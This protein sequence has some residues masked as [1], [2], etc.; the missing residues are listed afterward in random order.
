MDAERDMQ[1]YSHTHMSRGRR[2]V[3]RVFTW[4][5][6]CFIIAIVSLV[7]WRVLLSDRIPPDAKTLL[8]NEATKEAYLAHGDELIVCTQRQEKLTRLETDEGVYGLF[9]VSQSRFLPQAQQIQLLV[10]YNNST[11][12]YIAKD[13][14]LSEVPARDRDVIDVTLRVT[15]DP[16]PSEPKSGDEHTE[17]YHASAA[18]LPFSTAMY[19]YRAL[20]FDGVSIEDAAVQSISVDFYYLDRM[21]Y[22][23]LPYG[24]LCIF[25]AERETEPLELTARDRR[26]L[27][28]YRD[29]E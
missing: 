4:I 1:E 28:S 25:D 7:L 17:R 13:F 22:S 16:T 5:F 20:V 19:N 18:P 6:R 14:K 11:L 21:D 29:K 3:G 26:A 27:E 23:D 15:Y 24:T 10:R 12:D 9:W 8:V 2:I